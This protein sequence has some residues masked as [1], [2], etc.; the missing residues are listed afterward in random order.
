MSENPTSES[1]IEVGKPQECLDCLEIVGVGQTLTAS[2]FG[3]VHGDAS[4]VT[5][6][7]KKLNFCMWNSH[8]SGFEG[9]LYS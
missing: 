6:K 8:F 9:K 2:V 3:R 7:P 1:T 4:G 5:M